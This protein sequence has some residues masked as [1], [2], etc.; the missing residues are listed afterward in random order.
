[1]LR[2]FYLTKQRT[3]GCKMNKASLLII[4][5]DFISAYYMYDDIL[6]IDP[7]LTEAYNGKGISLF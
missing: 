6:R 1:M 4:K 7:K 2:Y 5:N 3:F